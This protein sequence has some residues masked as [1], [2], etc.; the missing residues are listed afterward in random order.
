MSSRDLWERKGNFVQHYL[1]MS[2][3]K[4]ARAVMEAGGFVGISS[5]IE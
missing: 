3:L 5:L 4:P 1:A 2:A